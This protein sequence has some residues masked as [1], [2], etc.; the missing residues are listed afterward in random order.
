M[1]LHA[2]AYLWSG[3]HRDFFTYGHHDLAHDFTTLPEKKN[4]R[5]IKKTSSQNQ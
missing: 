1:T 4:K 2:F 3:H 5:T